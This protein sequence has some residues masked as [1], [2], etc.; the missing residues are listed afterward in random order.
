V[1]RVLSR[2]LVREFRDI[3]GPDG[4]VTDPAELMVYEADGMPLTKNPPSCVLLP[5]TTEQVSSVVRLLYEN[6][7]PFVP[8]GAGTGLSGGAV[9]LHGAV[10]ITFSRM[11]RILEVDLANRRALVEAGVVNLALSQ[12]VESASYHF[13]P[14]PSSQMACH[15]GG[16][17]AEN[18]GGPHTL[19]YGVT[20]NHV[21]GLEMVLPDGTVV[22]LGG[23]GEQAAGYDLRGLVIGSEGTLGI[24]TK[25]LVR[26][27]RLPQSW[28][29]MLAVF[30]TLDDAS[31]CVTEIIASGIVPSALEMIDLVLLQAVEE[32]F[33]FGLPT[34][35][36]AVLIIE[37][38]GL[39][40][41]LDED[42][43]RVV[44]LCQSR[45]AREIRLA[46]DAKERD[47]LWKVRKK[48]IGAIGRISPDSRTQDGTVPRSKLP[49]V[50]RT[51]YAI[52]ERYGLKVGN[53]F[54][55]GDGNIHPNILFD[56][57]DEKQ[58]EIVHRAGREMLQAC[59]EAGGT[60]TGEHGVGLA[61]LELMPFQFTPQELSL[62]A[63][64]KRVFDPEGLCNPGKVLPETADG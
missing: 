12:R 17:V 52:G 49:E 1:L 30:D 24:V 23:S 64:V 9:P 48:A 27:V 19:K 32:A 34:D 57:R 62:M 33:H 25:V 39:E 5:R 63:R 15:I 10:C 53:V 37:L 61:K 2:Q 29:T 7:I 3:I 28:R 26:L 56:E 60:I 35:A 42:L 18:A 51:I 16:N 36:A 55:A 22:W 44:E 41:G 40:A 20:T 59:V 45:R 31:H 50:L 14:D 43:K 8:R 47:R 46:H 54:H 38:D 58:R 13:A 11:N 6:G 21:L 4:V